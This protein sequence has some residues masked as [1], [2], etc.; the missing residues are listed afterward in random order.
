ME[1]NKKDVNLDFR[2]IA[3][4]PIVTVGGKA[5]MLLRNNGTGNL[6]V[7]PLFL[8][9]AGTEEDFRIE[10]FHKLVELNK[11]NKLEPIMFFN[12]IN[13]NGTKEDII[14]GKELFEILC[15]SM[16]YHDSK[17]ALEETLKKYP[18][19]LRPIMRLDK[20]AVLMMLIVGTLTI[21]NLIL[22]FYGTK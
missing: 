15:A 16:D 4:S 1:N 7:F 12:Y 21:G 18:K 19:W 2:A 3:S 11:E 6:M 17:L 13:R 20:R 10:Y 5:T 9:Y 14:L 22:Y 8:D